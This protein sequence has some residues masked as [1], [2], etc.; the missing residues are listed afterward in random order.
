MESILSWYPLCHPSVPVDFCSLLWN[1]SLLRASTLVFTNF[2]FFHSIGTHDGVRRTSAD[3]GDRRTAECVDPRL[4]W[5]ATGR[6]RQF[7]T[8]HAF[9]LRTSIFIFA[10]FGHSHAIQ[11]LDHVR[12]AF[13]HAGDDWTT[14]RVQ[15][16]VYAF[17]VWSAI[18]VGT[19][20]F[21]GRAVDRLRGES[22]QN[23]QRD[24]NRGLHFCSGFTFPPV[25]L[26]R[27][28]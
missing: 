22:G 25:N 19:R 2:R 27:R 24:K 8:R 5:H 7:R 23:D 18:E 28:S 6:T 26:S 9:L 12:R 11:T 14:V 20:N 21:Q 4:G 15:S 16:R 1:A 10:N 17:A 3:A 13:V